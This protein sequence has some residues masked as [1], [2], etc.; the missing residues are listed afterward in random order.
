MYYFLKTVLLGLLRLRTWLLLLSDIRHG[1]KSRSFTSPYMVSI[2][3]IDRLLAPGLSH[4]NTFTDFNVGFCFICS[5]E[6]IVFRI[7]ASF[8]KLY[9][10]KISNIH[11]GALTVLVFRK[12]NTKFRRWEKNC[13][14]TS[15]LT[16][17]NS[18]YISGSNSPFLQFSWWLLRCKRSCTFLILAI[19]TATTEFGY[20]FA[21]L[22]QNVA[23]FWV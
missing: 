21:W 14:A 19:K 15:V 10:Y 5:F 22:S 4:L 16:P 8:F 13:S 7:F 18:L 6:G 23:G 20:L 9:W 12:V 2:R 3:I 11:S 1:F 17:S